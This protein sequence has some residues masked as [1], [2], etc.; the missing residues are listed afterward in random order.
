VS[1]SGVKN[2]SGPAVCVSSEGSVTPVTPLVGA[3]CHRA[4]SH[5]ALLLSL[6]HTMCTTRLLDIICIAHMHCSSIALVTLTHVLLGS[7]VIFPTTFTLLAPP[8]RRG[9][10]ICL[11]L[12]SQYDSGDCRGAELAQPVRQGG[13]PVRQGHPLCCSRLPVAS[14]CAAHSSLLV[15]PLRFRLASHHGFTAQPKS[16]L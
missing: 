4:V 5:S 12:S 6:S 16:Y 15:P 9:A 13:Q 14:I 3:L 8:P 10:Q 1:C 2:W 7:P 11:Q